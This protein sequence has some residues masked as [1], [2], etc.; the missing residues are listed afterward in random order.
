MRRRRRI[1][2]GWKEGKSRWE[3]NKGKGWKKESRR[4]IIRFVCMRKKG[5]KKRLKR[6]EKIKERNHRRGGKDGRVRRW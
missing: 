4:R 6:N 5:K 2:Y 1:V 3:E